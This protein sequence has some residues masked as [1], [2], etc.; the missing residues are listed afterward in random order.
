MLDDKVTPS[1][2]SYHRSFWALPKGLPARY[3][4]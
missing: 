1:P 3:K 4:G 2:Q